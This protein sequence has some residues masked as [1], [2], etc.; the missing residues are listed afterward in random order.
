MPPGLRDAFPTRT[1]EKPAPTP[2]PTPLK[3]TQELP[4]TLNKGKMKERPESQPH[5]SVSVEI[6][7]KT[8]HFLSL[9]QQI[10]IF[11]PYFAYNF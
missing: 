3:H 5:S 8:F 2:I 10:R 7:D 9:S 4:S 11:T 6:S 1:E